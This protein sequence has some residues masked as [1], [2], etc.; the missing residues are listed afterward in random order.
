VLCDKCKKEPIAKGIKKIIC[1]KC[2]KKT[3][4][5]INYNAD[6]CTVCSNKENTCQKCGKNL[7]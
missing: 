6:V 1:L 3:F 5:N 7:K 2:G 4:L